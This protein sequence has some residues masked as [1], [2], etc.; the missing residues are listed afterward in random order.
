[1]PLSTEYFSHISATG[2]TIHVFPGCHQYKAEAL[3]CEYEGSRVRSHAENLTLSQT[4][5][6]FTCL[7]YKS[8]KNTIEKGEIAHHEQFLLF[9][10][11]FLPF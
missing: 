9:Q 8:F 5:P 3:K 7:Q 2:H 6:C 10:K 4:S 11:C 1:M